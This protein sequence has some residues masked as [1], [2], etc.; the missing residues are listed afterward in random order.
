MF[1]NSIPPTNSTK[2]LNIKLQAAKGKTFV[3][4]AFWGALFPGNQ[5]RLTKCFVVI[6][7]IQMLNFFQNELPKMVEAGVRGF[8]GFMVAAGTDDFKMVAMRDIEIAYQTLVGKNTVLLVSSYLRW[9]PVLNNVEIT[10][11]GTKTIKC[12][13]Y[14]IVP[15]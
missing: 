14:S 11:L 7:T 15:C 6:S 5:V 4:V 8:K 3:D 2:N 1:R 10:P 9:A 12:F 13:N